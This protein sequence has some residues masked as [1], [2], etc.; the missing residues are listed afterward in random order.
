MSLHPWSWPARPWQCIHLDFAGPFMGSM[1]MVVVDAHSKWLEVIPMTTTTTE[2]TITELRKLF[3]AYGLPEQIVT[4]NGTQFTSEEFQMFMKQNA[5]KHIH[6][7]PYHPA[8]NGEAERFVQTFKRALKAAKSDP[9]STFDK[10]QRFLLSYRSTPNVTTAVSPAELFIKRPLRT[11][12]STIKPNL[13]AR[14]AEQQALQKRN[15][16]VK[17]K[18]REF[19]EGQSVL[20]ANKGEPKWLSGIIVKTLGPTSYNVQVGNKI[21]KRHTDQLL[22][23]HL[24]SGST[25]TPQ[26][27]EF[28]DSQPMDTTEESHGVTDNTSQLNSPVSNEGNRETHKYPQRRRTAPDRFQAGFN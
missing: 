28:D 25:D 21:W 10:L 9:G 20:V 27:E 5:V 14:V 16:D 13:S 19:Q 8:T 1:F 22:S 26:C 12:L 18:R 2:K 11:R 15:H 24:L 7:A 6:S 17:S 3:A 23:S 4:D